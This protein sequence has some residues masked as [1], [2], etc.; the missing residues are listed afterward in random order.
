[1]NDLVAFIRARLDEDEA[2]AKRVK[3]N[4][5]PNELRA[6][7]MREDSEPFLIVDSARV[8]REVEAKQRILD[9]H[10]DDDGFCRI[11]TVEDRQEN[12]LEE[13]RNDGPFMT[14]VRRPLW[15]PCPTLRL[16][17]LPYADHP[18]YREEWKP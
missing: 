2:T 7:V 5:S 8:L 17:A 12:T 11:C 3:P 1:M 15:H 4:Q 14:I 18:D 16:L 6:M 10:A 9:E 13:I